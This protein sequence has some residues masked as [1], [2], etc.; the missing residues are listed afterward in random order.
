[1]AKDLE[2]AKLGT[3]ILYPPELLAAIVAVI[4]A[5]ESRDVVRNIQVLDGIASTPAPIAYSM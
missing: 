3:L 5:Q 1:M 4:A 2:V